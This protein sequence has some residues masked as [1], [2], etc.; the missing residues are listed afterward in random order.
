MKPTPAEA[1]WAPGPWTHRDI[2]A[3][4]V[5]FHAVEAGTGPLVLLLHGFPQ[6]W[7]TWRHL[8]PTLA[9]AGYRAVAIDLRGYGGSDHTPHGYDPFTLSAD[10][11]G[12]VRALGESEAVL[13]GHGWGGLIAWSAA[14][15]RRPAVRAIAP[16]SMPH[17]NMLRRG[18]VSDPQ[19]RRA[20]RYAIG[21][22][23]PLA[24][25]RRLV[26]DDAER[27]GELLRLW[28]GTPGWPDPGTAAVYRSAIQYGATAHCALE[29]HRWAI[30]SIPRPD[31]RRFAERMN[32]PV[33]QPVL[34]IV[35]GNDGALLRTTFDGS[36]RFVTGRYECR[37]MAGVGHFPQEEDAAG[38]NAL[39]LRW[40]QSLP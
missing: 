15:L 28:S 18:L 23:V 36:E 24:P 16:I 27:V 2:A 34:Q 29:Y 11:A 3:N 40:L 14:V 6:F 33:N 10:A 38:L 39:V 7:W 17:P 13:I 22:Q 30:R 12:L 31:G 37:E 4:G 8:L 1:I 35:G 32:Q 9:D 21:F 20:S 5:R 19:Q 26:R 25:E